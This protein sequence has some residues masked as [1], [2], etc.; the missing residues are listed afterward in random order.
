M[1]NFDDLWATPELLENTDMKIIDIRT[2]SEW[3]QTGIVEDSYT[4][5][6]FNELGSY[7]IQEFQEELNKIIDKDEKFALICRTGSRTGQVASFLKNKFGYEVVSL[8]GGIL[9]LIGE[10]YQTK[11]YN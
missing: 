5:T 4:I 10:G 8:N 3:Q 1:Q 2:P 7:N 6:F 11:S 9:K